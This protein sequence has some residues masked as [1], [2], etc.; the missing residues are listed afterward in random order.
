[1][2]LIADETILEVKRSVDITEIVSGYIPLKRAGSSYKALCPFH[3]EKSPSF[4]VTPTRQTF[5][6][7]GCGKGGDAISFVMAHENV[8]Y[9]EAIRILAERS[10]I[11]VKYKEG[12]KEGL[13]RD[14]L[15]RVLEWAQEVFRGLLLKAPEAEIARAFLTR[16]GVSD[17][18]SDLFKLGFSMDSWDHL[19]QR[20]RKAGFD[21]K[22]L[23]AAGLAIEREGRGGYYDRFR[24]RV[25]F[26]I[27]D[28]RGRTIGFGARTLK[29]EQPKFLNSPETAVFSKGRGFYGLHLNKEEIEK[30]RTV[31]I[32]EGYL[33]VVIPHMAGVKGLVATLGTALTKDHLKI[34]RRYADKVVLVFDSDAA[35]QKA[36][37]R[38]LDLLLSENVDIFVASLPPG[39]DPDDVVIKQGADKLRECLEKP[40][41]IFGFLMDSLAARHGTST[42][43]AIGRIVQEM[44]ERINQIPDPVKQEILVQQLAAKFGIEERSLRGKLARQR[45]GESASPAAVEIARPA[46]PANPTMEKAGRELLAC[47]FADKTTAALIRK[48]CPAERYPSE[49]LRKIAATAYRLFDQNGE[50]LTSDLVA[51]LQDAAAMELAAAIGDLE[52]DPA[53]AP[54]RAAGCLLTMGLSEARSE[55]RGIQGRLNEAS[56]TEQREQLKKFQETKG[57]KSRV[58][59]RAFPGR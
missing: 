23:A 16:R 4:I 45:E 15:Y 10:G 2:A 29:D 1:M 54:D 49:L 38:G 24:G 26:P 36:S 46:T 56:E 40:R 41:E 25:V 39:M 7:F 27:H 33:D 58:N 13:G 53:K 30:T 20:G 6:C 17:E 44:L 18:T 14:D 9:P 50:I 34:L 57:A 31:Y 3:E 42:P 37:E 11:L 47:A 8:D 28:P 21:D 19:L 35:G 59:P 52:V 22:T 48:E 32:V 12:G 55:Y 51:L 43:A 5:K